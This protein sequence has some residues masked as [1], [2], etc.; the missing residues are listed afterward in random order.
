MI[1]AKHQ[2]KHQHVMYVTYVRTD[3]TNKYNEPL[4]KPELW[5]VLGRGSIYHLVIFKWNP[6][7]FSKYIDNLSSHELSVCPSV[8]TFQNQ[9][10]LTAG[11]SRLRW[12][13]LVDHWW[14]LSC[15]NFAFTPGSSNV[16]VGWH[17]QNDP[18]L[19]FKP[20]LTKTR[21]EKGKDSELLV[22]NDIIN[23]EAFRFNLKTPFDKN[24]I[25]QMEV[26]ETLFDYTFAHLGLNNN[27]E[28]GIGHPIVLT[29][30]VGNPNFCRSR[31]NIM[32]SWQQ[33]VTRH[34]S[35]MSPSANPTVPTVTTVTWKCFWST[36]PTHS[37]DR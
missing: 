22:A 20:V 1:H 6:S 13:S 34:V 17:T 27:G 5:F 31:K 37:H 28:G 18:S 32:N 4:F 14:L 21:R 19:V 11:R 7:M 8:S 35:L 24:V 15:M 33:I 9:A 3:T 2:P 36:N 12:A 30:P 10:K 16:R 29:E 26:A 23:I 25:V